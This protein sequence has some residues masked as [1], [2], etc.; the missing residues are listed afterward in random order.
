MQIIKKIYDNEPQEE[1]KKSPPKKKISANRI[2]HSYEYKA[3]N[4]L[5]KPEDCSALKFKKQNSQL[6]ID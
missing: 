5:L 3:K 4:D 2:S 6:I 1:E